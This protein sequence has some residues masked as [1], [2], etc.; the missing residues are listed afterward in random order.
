MVHEDEVDGLKGNWFGKVQ[1]LRRLASFFP[2]QAR[3][4]GRPGRESLY[5]F[6]DFT[7]LVD[8]NPRKSDTSPNSSCFS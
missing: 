4:K 1:V 5:P 2:P 8:V 6:F 7:M 3:V